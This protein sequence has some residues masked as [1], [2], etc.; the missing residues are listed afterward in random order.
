MRFVT[1]GSDELLTRCRKIGV[2]PV[3]VQALFL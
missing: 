2:D 3:R 1:F